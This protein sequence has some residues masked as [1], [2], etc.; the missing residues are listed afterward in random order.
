MKKSKFTE[1]QIAYVLKQAE[2]G[3]GLGGVSLSTVWVRLCTRN[4]RVVRG[5]PILGSAL[6]TYSCW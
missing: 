6:G 1:E 3:K 2:L 4:L 5:N